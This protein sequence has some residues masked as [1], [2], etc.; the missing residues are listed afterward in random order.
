[1]LK[2]DD[3]RLSMSSEPFEPNLL[4][5]KIFAKALFLEGI[6]SEELSAVTFVVPVRGN[7]D[8]GFAQFEL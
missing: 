4:D 1:V 3:P 8:I 6:R 5:E 7:N 2:P